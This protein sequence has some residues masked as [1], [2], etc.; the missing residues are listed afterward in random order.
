DSINIIA[1]EDPNNAPPI[2]VTDSTGNDTT[3]NCSDTCSSVAFGQAAQ[4]MKLHATANDYQEGDRLLFLTA[5]GKKMTSVVLTTDADVAGGAIKFRFAS[6]NADGTNTL[7]NDPLNIT[8]CGGNK[9][10]TPN[11]F[12]AQ[13][14]SSDWIIKL[15]PVTYAVDLSDTANPKLM[16]TA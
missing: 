14:C 3:A 1:G 13:F 6:T 12:G 4:G 5:S 7:A 16:R 10:P 11:N 2:N 8:A 9:C 15:A